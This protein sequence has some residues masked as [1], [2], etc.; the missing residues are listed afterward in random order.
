MSYAGDV[1][2]AAV[3]E[4]PAGETDLRGWL[5][6]RAWEH[7]QSKEGSSS[8]EDSCPVSMNQAHEIR[9]LKGLRGSFGGDAVT[10]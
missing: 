3:D 4:M 1:L 8:C 5:T 9:M 2:R 10:A 6:A 7:D